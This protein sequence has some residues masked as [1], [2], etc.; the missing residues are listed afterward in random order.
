MT[1]LSGKAALITLITLAIPGYEYY[2]YCSAIP[3]TCQAILTALYRDTALLDLTRTAL[4]GDPCCTP[5]VARV[6]GCYLF[7]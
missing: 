1:A 3:R 7:S 5:N 4:S 2:E 6:G